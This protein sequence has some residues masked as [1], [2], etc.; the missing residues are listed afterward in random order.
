M[1]RLL[2]IMLA[3]L[4]AVPAAAEGT[5]LEGYAAQLTQEIRLLIADESYVAMYTGGSSEALSRPLKWLSACTW[6][7]PTH[8]VYL[9][10][11]MDVL[12]AAL[13]VPNEWASESMSTILP[14]YLPAL[15]RYAVAPPTSP[16]RMIIT[17]IA[18]AD[19]TYI[20]SAQPDGVMMFIRFYADG[21]PV[22]FTVAAQDSAVVL[23]AEAPVCLIGMPE[24]QEAE[25]LRKYL[26]ENEMSFVQLQEE[27][28]MLSTGGFPQVQGETLE[29]R[30]ASLAEEAGCRMADQ[31]RRAAF[32]LTAA[33]DSLIAGWAE[34]DYTAPRLAAIPELDVKTHGAPLWGI[35]A[36]K[37]LANEGSPA[38]RQL[39]GMLYSSY[40]GALLNRYGGV[41]TFVAANATTAQAFF[42]DPA[43]PDG[44]G[45]YLLGYEGG[46]MMLVSWMAENGVVGMNA[47]YLPLP[48]LAACV[49]ATE[50]F[51]WFVMNASP[52]VCTGVEIH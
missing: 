22:M 47:Q 36:V 13:A 8:D 43:Q 5:L 41:D 2:L 15:A 51:K 37:V 18:T 20:D 50:M 27:P 16:E 3:L 11:D 42:A 24:G 10:I 26:E 44:M 7:Q 45:A 23:T 4:L 29:Q 34:A 1:K 17:R 25:A 30:A 49:D 32:G 14:E 52:V 48:E 9:S 39:N 12:N 35:N 38:A 31:A 33:Q 40:F 46:H 6:Q 19:V 28:V 21:H